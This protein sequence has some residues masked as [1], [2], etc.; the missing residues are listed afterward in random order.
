MEKIDYS[1]S[2]FTSKGMVPDQGDTISLIWGRKIVQAAANTYGMIGTMNFGGGIGYRM[3]NLQLTKKYMFPP[4]V[5]LYWKDSSG[6][7]FTGKQLIPLYGE[8]I[9]IDTA[10]NIQVPPGLY[11][12]GITYMDV[13]DFRS[14]PYALINGDGLCILV[15]A[16]GIHE[17]YYRIVG[18]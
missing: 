13:A 18:V 2:Y 14:K 7:M 10:D 5:Y 11:Y 3:V 8:T 9:G 12:S 1:N 15:P 6:T 4:D 16:A 17:L